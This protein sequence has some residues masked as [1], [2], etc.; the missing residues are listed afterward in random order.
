LNEAQTRVPFIVANLPI[1]VPEPFVQSE[2]RPALLAAMSEPDAARPPRSRPR[3]DAPIFQYLG[4]P[5]RPRQLA[6][7]R[8]GGRFIYDFR[9]RRARAPSGD[10]LS[11]DQLPKREREE[12][13][14]LVRF[15]ERVQLARRE[16]WQRAN[17]DG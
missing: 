7:L 9:S 15:W 2:L 5:S 13:L 16:A 1:E 17:E 8:A 4:D 14:E 11:P 10:W 3:G 6:F 12:F